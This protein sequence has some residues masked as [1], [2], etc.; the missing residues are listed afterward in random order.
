MT[1]TNSETNLSVNDRT[2][3]RTQ[4]NIWERVKTIIYDSGNHARRRN[5]S[6]HAEGVVGDYVH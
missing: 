5:F 4:E 1:S 6:V 3:Y 2:T